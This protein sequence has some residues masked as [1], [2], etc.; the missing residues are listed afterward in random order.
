[1]SEPIKPC[2][3]PCPKC[4]SADIHRRFWPKDER[5]QA[6]GYGERN[7]GPYVRVEC[8]NAAASR[9]HIVHHC[10]CCQY[11]WSTLPLAKK[12]EKQVA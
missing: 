3:L 4:G 5:R 8:W 12:P 10:R 6:K 7:M 11:E 1:M 2:D 9:D